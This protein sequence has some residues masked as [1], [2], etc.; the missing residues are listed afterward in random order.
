MQ[1]FNFEI[2]K[3]YQEMSQVAANLVIQKFQ[4]QPTGLYCFAGGD[5]PVGTLNLLVDAHK[6][7]IIDLA[8]AYYIEL[9]EWVGLDEQNSGSC[10]AYLKRELFDPAGVPD[11]QVHYFNAL[12]VDLLEECQRANQVIQEHGGVTLSLLGV[13]VNGHL[14]FN[15]PG[16]S[17]EN[18]AHVVELDESTQN[19]GQKYF[20]AEVDR[21]KGITLGIK[22]LLDSELLIVEAS[23]VKKKAAIKQLLSVEVPVNEWPVTAVRTHK[24]CYV[25][26]DQAVVD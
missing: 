18:Q 26:V 5:T 9:D 15:E 13:G 17:F 1:P 2:T 24:N 10:I 8:K 11:S 14:G 22:Q 12:A 23:G 7:G 25:I 21:S 6:N 16:V 4:E 3:D 20:T 19:V